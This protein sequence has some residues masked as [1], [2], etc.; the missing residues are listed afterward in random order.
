MS[1]EPTTTPAPAPDPATVAAFVAELCRREYHEN[2]M[3]DAER[4]AHW[5]QALGLADVP[6]SVEPPAEDTPEVRL[7]WQIGLLEAATRTPG[8][9]DRKGWSWIAYVPPTDTNFKGALAHANLATVQYALAV[10]LAGPP[11]KTRKAAILRRIAA[12]SGAA[13]AQRRRRA[14]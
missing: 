1:A 13:P 8:E 11:H 2:P 10:A 9:M 12:L 7:R 5:R 6:L 14:A 3:L 4:V